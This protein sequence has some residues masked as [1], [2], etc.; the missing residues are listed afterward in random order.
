MSV[1]LVVYA[2]LTPGANT[3]SG[4]VAPWQFT[5][6]ATPLTDA[7]SNVLLFVPLGAALVW[8]SA[9]VG[10]AAAIGFAFS[11]GIELLQSTGH[12]VGRYATFADLLANSLGGVA[13]ALIAATRMRWT[14]PTVGE[15]RR[16]AFGWSAMVVVI[17]VLTAWLLSP[18]RR[19]D[20]ELSPPTVSRLENA[21]GFPWFAGVVT[22]VVVSGADIPHSGTGP[23]R[24]AASIGARDA[25]LVVRGRDSRRA[26]VPLLYLH[27]ARDTTAY[28][29]VG[30]FGDDAVARSPRRGDAMGLRMPQLVLAGVFSPARILDVGVLDN[31]ISD[32]TVRQ[33]AARVSARGLAMRELPAKGGASVDA[34]VGA[35]NAV[36]SATTLPN[37]ITARL[38]FTPTLGWLMVQPVIGDDET[39][40]TVGTIA[41]LLLLVVPAL[42]WSWRCGAGRGAVVGVVLG[43]IFGVF[44][45][46]P[47]LFDVGP[48]PR[49]Q[50]GALLA[51]ATIGI[52]SARWTNS[53]DS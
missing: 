2:T 45:L 31:A 1:A 44:L 38:D 10:V 20:T 40:R 29:V 11:L 33:L 17:V 35:P 19:G 14:R 28:M 3:V 21:P 12:P 4:G 26:F 23:A 30:Q 42:F 41:W 13:G 39:S 5:V 15:A 53:A 51:A 16:L 43:S 6:G 25:M 9:R 37:S 49:W 34:M 22:R 27:D 46:A 36:V 52:L 32:V 47:L 50:W 8:A 18:V 24:V 7:L 48:L